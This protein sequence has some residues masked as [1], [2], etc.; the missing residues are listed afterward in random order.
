MALLSL[1]MSPHN[2]LEDWDV[3][4]V[5]SEIHI[6]SYYLLYILSNFYLE[7]KWLAVINYNFL[8]NWNV[9]FVF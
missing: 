2:L 4:L 3:Y 6:I 8:I 1:F 9:K 7:V 5:I